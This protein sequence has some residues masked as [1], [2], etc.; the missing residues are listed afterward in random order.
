MFVLD[1]SKVWQQDQNCNSSQAVSIQK[2][3][4][5]TARDM[6]CSLYMMEVLDVLCLSCVAAFRHVASADIICL[7]IML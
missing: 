6:L 7:C 1:F 5:A 4:F 3:G 2:L